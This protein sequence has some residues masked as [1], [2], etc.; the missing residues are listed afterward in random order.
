MYKIAVKKSSR[1]FNFYIIFINMAINYTSSMLYKSAYN[2]PFHWENYLPDD[3]FKYHLLVWKETNTSVDLRMGV[4]LP[5][6]LACLGPHTKGHF[7]TR[8]SVLNLFK[9]VTR[10]RFI[11]E[12]L[13][14]ILLN[15]NG[16]IPDFEI[17]RFTRPGI[18]LMLYNSKVLFKAF[19]NNE[20]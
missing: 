6:I 7:L 12:H 14:Y 2:I 18:S 10:H 4:V 15:S 8:P 13:D 9:S 11:S 19:F 5:F 17:S 16:E 20:Y 1:T 3:I